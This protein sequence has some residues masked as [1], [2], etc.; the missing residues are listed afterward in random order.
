MA[1]LLGILGKKLGM[2]RVFASDGTVV[3]VTV[4]SAGPCP[5]LQIK[6]QEHEGYDALQVGYDAIAERKA[7]KPERGHQ[8]KAGKGFFRHLRE[9]RLDKAEGYELGQELT[10]EMFKPGEKVKVTATSKGK[11]FQGPMKRHNFRGLGASH[12]AEKVHRSPGGIGMHTWPGRV[13]KNK[14]MAGQM[15]NERVTCTNVEIVDV[16]PEENILVLKGQVPG[17]KDGLVMI[18]KK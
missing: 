17:P 15:G 11:G 2:T 18:R 5:V 1:N 10:V 6:T 16:R 13:F 12:G 8:A 3:P 7:T 9:F 14:R 4:V